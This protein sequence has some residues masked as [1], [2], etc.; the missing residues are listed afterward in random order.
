MHESN[1]INGVQPKALGRAE[2]ALLHLGGNSLDRIRLL[3]GPR[4]STRRGLAVRRLMQA[5]L[6]LS[7]TVDGAG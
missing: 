6:G 2:L 1:C 5:Y 3:L 7:G 4:I